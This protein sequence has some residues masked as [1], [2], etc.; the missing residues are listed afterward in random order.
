VEC[1]NNLEKKRDKSGIPPE[2]PPARQLSEEH[3]ELLNRANR[4]I[5]ALRKINDGRYTGKRPTIEQMKE[6]EVLWKAY[7]ELANAISRRATMDRAWKQ[8]LHQVGTARF[9]CGRSAHT[10][11]SM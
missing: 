9:S 3:L 10:R 7:T 4:A 1:L 8:Q 11:Y 5:E 2:H 6:A